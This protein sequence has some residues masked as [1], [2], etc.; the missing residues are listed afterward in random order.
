MMLPS[1]P[2]TAALLALAFVLP[3]AAQSPLRP[4]ERPPEP[5]QELKRPTG[6][7]D[8]D[9]LFTLLQHAPDRDTAKLVEARIWGQ[10]FSSGSDTADL[11]MARARAAMDDN[12]TEVALQLLDALVTVVPD[13]VEAWNRRATVNYMRKDYGSALHDVAET[14]A[15]EPRHFGA[16]VGL[17]LILED[18]GQEKQALEA[19]RQALAINPYLERVPDLIKQLAPKVEGREI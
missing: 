14:L 2:L 15:R 8:L 16:L 19:F 11:L 9:R 1:R 13:Y 3:V 6:R 12:D 17:G 18:I 5:P 7:A 10:W 4:P